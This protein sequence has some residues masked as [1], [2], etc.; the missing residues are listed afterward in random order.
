MAKVVGVKFRNT[1]KVYYF[2]GKAGEE[3]KENDGVIVETAKGEEYGTV[4][5]G[6]KEVS[7]DS[8]V[9]PLKPII[10]KTTEKDEKIMRE[11]EKKIPETMKIAEEKIR[12]RNLDMKLVGCEYSYDGKKIVL[13]F[14]ADGRVDFRELV[15]DLA[16]CFHVRIELRQI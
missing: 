14:S 16:S 3:Y 12:A 15:K 11:N 8:V 2:S 1:S 7:D 13:Y 4:V 5:F 10:R 9:S 6:E